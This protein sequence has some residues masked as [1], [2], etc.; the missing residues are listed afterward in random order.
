MKAFAAVVVTLAATSASAQ[1]LTGTLKK[2]KDA[3]AISLGIRDTSVPFSFLNEKQQPVGY[4]MDLCMK[5]VDAVKAELNLPNLQVKHIP[6]ISQTR[7]PLVANGTVDLECGSTTNTLTRQKQAEFSPVTFI[8]GT[9][10]LVKAKSGIKE[11]ED[12]KG[13]TISVSQGTTNERV[14]KNLSEKLNLGIKVLNVKDHAEGF[15]VLESGRVDANVSDDVQLYGL[16][17]NARNPSDY[18]V[19]GRTLSY[20]PFGLMFRRGDPDFKLL[21]AKTLAGLM[22]SG[23]MEK[24]HA[25]WFG[26][27][28]LAVDEATKAAFAL[29]ALPE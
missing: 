9:R 6:V 10:L 4:S 2:I 15:L 17:A 14:I 28:G 19:V 16:K 24:L 21:V 20:E 29:Q 11:V 18:A 5:V 23:E 26:P 27:L 8:G 25:K 22:R 12:L 7:I 3:N 1:D 13:K